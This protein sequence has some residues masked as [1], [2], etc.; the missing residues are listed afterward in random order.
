MDMTCELCKAAGG[1]LLWQDPRCR[2][3]EVE[4]PDYPGFCRVIWNNHV[5]EMTDLDSTDRAHFM[6]IVFAVE[7]VLRE[8]LRPEKINLASLGNQVA[9]LHWHVIP[10]FRDDPHFPQPVWGERQR[11]ANSSPDAPV[12]TSML[13]G[14][15]KNINKNS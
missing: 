5:R 4:T 15:I 11:A 14:A 6:G 1:T 7:Q 13:R 3:V 2:I 12:W 9:H 10:R 8:V